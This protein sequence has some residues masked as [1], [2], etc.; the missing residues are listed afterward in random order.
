MFDFRYHALSLVAVLVAI[1]IGLLLGV[2][3]G[4]AGLVSGAEE[5]LR[6][7]LRGDVR[8]ARAESAGLRDE[9]ARRDR[10]E[11]QTLAPLVAGRL[12]QRRVALLFVGGR[13]DA[14]FRGVR[15]AIE[16]SGGEL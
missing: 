15:D 4:D 1:V 5:N 2:A 11:E 12:E 6:S 3:I 16:P 9:L 10:Y 7:N 8:A 14:V 13:S